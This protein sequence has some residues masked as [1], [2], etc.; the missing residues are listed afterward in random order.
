MRRTLRVSRGNGRRL[1]S[2]SHSHRLGI[3]GACTKSL[4]CEP[5]VTRNVSIGCSAA[6]VMS[7]MCRVAWGRQQLVPMLHGLQVPDGA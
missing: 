7:V 3:R 5:E 6:D 1:V 2:H 4:R